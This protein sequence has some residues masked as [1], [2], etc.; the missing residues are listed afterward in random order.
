[1]RSFDVFSMNCYDRRPPGDQIE[2]V[3]RRLEMPAILGEWH[4]GSLDAG[5]P[6]SGIGHVP[7]QSDR[8]RAYRAYLESAAAGQWCVG[9]HWFTLYDQSAVG[10]FDGENYNIGLL[11]VCHRPYARLVEAARA[12]HARMYAVA[13]GQE[14]P[15]D[16]APEY[17]ERLFM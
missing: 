15:F 10:R 4:F 2:P 14:P 7:T 8:G 11:D 9:A 5:L 16:D 13:A 6:A 12:S 3:C 1:M 17:L